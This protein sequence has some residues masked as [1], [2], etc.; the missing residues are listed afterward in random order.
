MGIVFNILGVLAIA[1]GIYLLYTIFRSVP[2][3]AGSGYLAG[4]M[5]GSL[6]AFSLVG[7]GLLFLAIGSV[8]NKLS[9]ISYWSR[10]AA[11]ASEE[12]GD[13]FAAVN[14][15]NREAEKAQAKAGRAA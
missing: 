7:S 15:A 2:A 4:A 9:D 6:P 1:V 11:L 14:K 8:L 5:L 3:D 10:R 13:Y 12:A